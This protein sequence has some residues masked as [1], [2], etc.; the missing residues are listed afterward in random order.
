VGSTWNGAE[1]VRDPDAPVCG[2]GHEVS[3]HDSSEPDSDV[4]DG[5]CSW[6][7]CLYPHNPG[8]SVYDVIAAPSDDDVEF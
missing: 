2:C 7:G 6:C 3:E 5:P 8:S 4:C 1:L